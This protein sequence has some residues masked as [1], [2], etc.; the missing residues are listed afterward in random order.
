LKGQ[1]LKIFKIFKLRGSIEAIRFCKERRALLFD[2]LSKY[3]NFDYSSELQ[4]I[5]KDLRSLLMDDKQLS[6][7]SMKLLLTVYSISRAFRTKPDA[8]LIP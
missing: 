2:L 1:I 4:R 5:P 7:P 3:N 6:V 8:N